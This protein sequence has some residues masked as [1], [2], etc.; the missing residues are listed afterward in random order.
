M[1]TAGFPPFGMTFSFAPVM[2][3]AGF[4]P[5]GMT[6]SLAAVMPTAEFP[7]FGMTTPLESTSHRHLSAQ[8]YFFEAE[9][10]IF[11]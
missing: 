7:P 4:P 2:P 5:F 1:P 6:F 11:L 9:N 10:A 3:T 8:N